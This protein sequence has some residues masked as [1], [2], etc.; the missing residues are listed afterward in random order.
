MPVV[1]QR[2]VA[3]VLTV[4]TPL[5]ISQLQILDKV[6]DM[7]VVAQQQVPD[8]KNSG[9]NSL[10]NVDSAR[11]PRCQS[12]SVV[13]VHRQ[14]R[15]HPCRGAEADPCGPGDSE[16]V[17]DSTAALHR[18][19]ARCHRVQVVQVHRQGGRCPK[20]CRSTRFHRC[21]SWKPVEIPRVVI[22]VDRRCDLQ[23]GSSRKPTCLRRKQHLKDT[24]NLVV[25]TQKL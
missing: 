7:P 4:Q 17:S 6:V 15:R 22:M 23:Y 8:H 20:W 14:G 25:R 21:R 12:R 11:S 5:E 10:P 24:A 9:V 19:G 1:V 13:A 2:Q 16:D 3:M 18:Q